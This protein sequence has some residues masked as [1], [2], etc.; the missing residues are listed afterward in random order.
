[1]TADP[2]IA[3]NYT[4]FKNKNINKESR[5]IQLKNTKNQLL[6]VIYRETHKMNSQYCN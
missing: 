3:K 1:M 4:P 6:K 2:E 5:E